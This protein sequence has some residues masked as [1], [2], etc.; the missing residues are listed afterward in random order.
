MECKAKQKTKK[1]TQES[2]P[3]FHYVYICT[4]IVKVN[5]RRALFFFGFLSKTRRNKTGKE[6]EEEEEEQ[7]ERKKKKKKKKKK[8]GTQKDHELPLAAQGLHS[9]PCRRSLQNRAMGH[10]HSWITFK[11][12]R[13]STQPTGRF[14]GT[15][16]WPYLRERGSRQSSQSKPYP[17]ELWI[18]RESLYIDN[19]GSFFNWQ[20]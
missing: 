20:K 14:L 18:W 3:L 5:K 19:T 17:F 7:K 8:E 2:P 15:H 11:T 9:L 16:P 10:L 12:S 6:E 1:K 4:Y 13:S